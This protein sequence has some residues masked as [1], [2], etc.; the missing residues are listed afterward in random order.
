MDQRIQRNPSLPRIIKVYGEAFA[1]ATPAQL[2]GAIN[3]VVR[4][5]LTVCTLSTDRLDKTKFPKPMLHEVEFGDAQ[6]RIVDF[7]VLEGWVSFHHSL[8][9]LLADLT[10]HVDILLEES[11]KQVG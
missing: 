8:H 10:E 2:V 7:N 5:I 3:I 4:E 11:L 6:Y 1:F 9:W